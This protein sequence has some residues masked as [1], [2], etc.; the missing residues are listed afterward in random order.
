LKFKAFVIQN[1]GSKEIWRE[2][3]MMKIRMIS[4]AMLLIFFIFLSCSTIQEHKGASYGVGAGAATGAVIGGLTG[5]SVTGVIVGGLLGGLAGGA[6]GHYAY[7]KQKERDETAKAENYDPA[8]GPVL[9]IENASASP[10]TVNPGDQVT[11]KLTYYVLN[12]S[13]DIQTKV[14]ETRE[15]IHNGELVG[16]PEITITRMD[17]TYTSTVPVSLPRSAAAGEY[18]VNNTVESPNLR[19]TRT[20]RFTVR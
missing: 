8:K 5:R 16:R 6:I 1:Y 9:R 4:A 7:D 10:Q 17:G 20:V 14:T 11:L 15:I 13:K 19:D 3:V 18:V 2:G 12:P